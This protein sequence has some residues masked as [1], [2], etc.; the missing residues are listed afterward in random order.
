MY[1]STNQGLFKLPH[2]TGKDS[3]S[4]VQ[5]IFS[6]DQL[7][8]RYRRA[9]DCADFCYLLLEDDPLNPIE[10]SVGPD[11]FDDFTAKWACRTA[12][13]IAVWS[14]GMPF[15]PDDFRARLE[16]HARNGRFITLILTRTEHHFAWLGHALKWRR[17]GTE[18][19]EIR[20]IELAG[21][22]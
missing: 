3:I 2:L 20:S 8:R 4:C 18:I 16:R 10:R 17:K 11:G 19:L 9:L 22:M 14:A 21:V 12:S 7:N 1:I 13:F 6:T 5:S 15:D